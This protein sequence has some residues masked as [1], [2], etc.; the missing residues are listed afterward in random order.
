MQKTG[1]DD[2]EPYIF[3]FYNDVS[4]NGQVS[5]QPGRPHQPSGFQDGADAAGRACTAVA[6]R[7]VVS[8]NG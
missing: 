3:S 2:E 4:A 6:Q 5:S 7:L 1:A 8:E